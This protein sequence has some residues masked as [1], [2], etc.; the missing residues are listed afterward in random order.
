MGN[1]EVGQGRE[2]GQQRESYQV[3]SHYGQLVLSPMRPLG[4]GVGHIARGYL[5][6]VRFFGGRSR[7]VGH[8]ACGVVIRD[9]TC[10]RRGRK[11]DWAESWLELQSWPGKAWTDPWGPLRPTM[12]PQSCK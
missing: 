8:L 5:S 4:D 12:A 2:G 9:S 7:N 11:S 10:G 6:W 1:G 3:G